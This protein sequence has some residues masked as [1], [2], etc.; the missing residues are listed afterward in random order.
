MFFS[1]MNSNK[2]VGFF[3]FLL[4]GQFELE[5]PDSWELGKDFSVWKNPRWKLT[6][7]SQCTARSKRPIHS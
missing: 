7:V 5:I 4:S 3:F 1:E 6:L 2:M